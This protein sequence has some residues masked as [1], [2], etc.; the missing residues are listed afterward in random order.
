MRES[1]FSPPQTQSWLMRTCE[2]RHSRRY[3]W[4]ST[5]VHSRKH[6]WHSTLYSCRETCTTHVNATTPFPSLLSRCFP[7]PSVFGGNLGQGI[8]PPSPSVL[9]RSSSLFF[10]M[11]PVLHASIGQGCIMYVIT[12]N[13]CGGG[14]FVLSLPNSVYYHYVRT[15]GTLPSRLSFLQ[16][17]TRNH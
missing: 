5:Y 7:G 11:V 9:L 2:F 17:A 4:E 3:L 10:L 1:L 12:C 6:T 15:L 16:S 8:D 14:I 13:T